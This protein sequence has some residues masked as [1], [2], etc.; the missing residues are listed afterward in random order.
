MKST[1]VKVIER[2]TLFRGYSRI[3]HY[4]LQYRLFDGLWSKR[5]DREVFEVGHG[6]LVV[7]FD[8]D[9][10]KVVLVEQ[11]RQGA[12][13]ALSSPWFDTNSSPWTLECVAGNLRDN[14]IPEE[15]AE[16]ESKEE[17][18]CDIKDL[19]PVGH[20]LVSPSSSSQSVFVFCAR[21]DASKVDGIH[22]LA[23]EGE[24][25]R[26]F[27]VPT[28]EV[29]QWLE[30]GKIMTFGAVIG[31]QWLKLNYEDLKDRWLV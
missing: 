3:D 13:A 23:E 28:P 10:D 20:Y 24:Q 9:L 14:E 26:A 18:G 30:S 7:L 5:I 8:P 29:F 25:T 27:A 31:L 11:F 12:F 15:V 1:D 17:A 4:E 2:T 19:I 22:G 6:V 21:I 16:R